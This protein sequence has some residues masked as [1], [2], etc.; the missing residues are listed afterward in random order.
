MYSLGMGDMRARVGDGRHVC[1]CVYLVWGMVGTRREGHVCT[2]ITPHW[3]DLRVFLITPPPHPSTC[4][5]RTYAPSS[6]L[7]SRHDVGRV[8]FTLEKTLH[9]FADEARQIEFLNG[10]NH[11]GRVFGRQHFEL[12]TPGDGAAQ[13]LS[14]EAGH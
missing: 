11:L 13:E 14:H 2:I 7:H 9:E 4:I 1:A 3:K 12:Q 10:R 5:S 8:E 6:H